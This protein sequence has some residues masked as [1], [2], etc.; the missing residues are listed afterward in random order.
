ML[1]SRNLWFSVMLSLRGL[2]RMLAGR[3]TR[4][5]WRGLEA[6]VAIV[7]TQCAVA[8]CCGV[9]NE[10]SAPHVLRAMKR[11]MGYF[12]RPLRPSRFEDGP[13]KEGEGRGE[14]RGDDGKF[15][16]N[17]EDRRIGRQSLPW[18]EKEVEPPVEAEVPRRKPRRPRR[19]RRVL[20]R[21]TAEAEN[22]DW[23]VEHREP[24]RP[25]LMRR[26]ERRVDRTEPEKARKADPS[27]LDPPVK[28]VNLDA[29]AKQGLPLMNLYQLEPAEFYAYIIKELGIERKYAKQIWRWI[30]VKGVQDLAGFHGAVIL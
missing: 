17:W 26:R 2:R 5:S 29:M 3:S 1:A 12:R 20:R 6:L 28:P 9:R 24:W 16:V 11:P 25:P 21:S 14:W 13:E 27:K 22:D 23:I 18:E 10:G 19:Q 15:T 8:F 7:L 4:R 30:F